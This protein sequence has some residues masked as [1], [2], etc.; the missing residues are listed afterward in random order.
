MLIRWRPPWTT[1]G[2]K[3]KT[4]ANDNIYHYTRAEHG[5]WKKKKILDLRDYVLKPYAIMSPF[6]VI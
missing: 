1:I 2:I 3:Q 6:R 4:N 5:N